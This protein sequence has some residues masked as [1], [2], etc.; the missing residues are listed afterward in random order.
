MPHFLASWRSS[1]AGREARLAGPGPRRGAAGNPAIRLP[2]A[3]MTYHTK[4]VPAPPTEVLQQR[5]A[6]SHGATI[7][8][9][10]A[11]GIRSVTISWWNRPSNYEDVLQKNRVGND[12]AH[13]IDRRVT[14][15]RSDGTDFMRPVRARRRSR[16][17]PSPATTIRTTRLRKPFRHRFGYRA[18]WSWARSIKQAARPASLAPGRTSACMPTATMWPASFQARRLPA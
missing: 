18:C 4:P 17:S 10:R 14:V 2:S 15:S 7:A 1:H 12:P 6:P 3:L 11:R 13:A 16:F 5:V 8:C 9:F